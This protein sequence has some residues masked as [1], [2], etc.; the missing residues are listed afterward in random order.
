MLQKQSNNF[1]LSDEFLCKPFMLTTI[2]GIFE[3][4]IADYILQKCNRM[5]IFYH[6]VTALLILFY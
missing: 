2:N 6:S 4:L 5:I 1:M 3:F